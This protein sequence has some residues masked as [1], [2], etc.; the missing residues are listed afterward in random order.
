MEESGP[1]P[2]QGEANG[3]RSLLQLLGVLSSGRHGTGVMGSCSREGE[4]RSHLR[5]TQVFSQ[6]SRPQ[7]SPPGFGGLPLGVLPFNPVLVL[8][9]Q[10]GTDPTG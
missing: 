4:Q 10:N 8:S 3:P 6:Y 9:A 1:S 7:V 5:E 2:F